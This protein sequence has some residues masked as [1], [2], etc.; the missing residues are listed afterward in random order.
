MEWLDVSLEFLAIAIRISII[1]V[2]IKVQLT[3]FIGQ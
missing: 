2:V 1:E 3:F